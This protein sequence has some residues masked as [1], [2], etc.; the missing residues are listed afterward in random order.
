M[1]CGVCEQEREKGH[2]LTLTEQ[3]R[4]YVKEQTGEDVTTFFY[5]FPC[6]NLMK[7]RMAG[8]SLIRGTLELNLRSIGHPRAHDMAE[9]FYSDLVKLGRRD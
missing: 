4:Q 8:A 5:C 7:D 9:R 2:V 6:W 3:E 1:K